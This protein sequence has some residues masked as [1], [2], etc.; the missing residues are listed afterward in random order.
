MIL[1]PNCYIL[2]LF[3]FRNVSSDGK[4]SVVKQDNGLVLK[5]CHRVVFF[6]LDQI[7]T[8]FPGMHVSNPFPGV[9]FAKYCGSSHY[10][11]CCKQPTLVTTTNM[12]PSFCF[13]VI[14]LYC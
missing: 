13:E 4:T 1:K 3:F 14:T 12:K 8:G 6:F 5:V 10:S 11:H 2:F 9:D 7:E